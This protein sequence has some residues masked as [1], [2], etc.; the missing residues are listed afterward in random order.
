[1]Y[2]GKTFSSRNDEVHLCEK[3]F[4]L[5]PHLDK[6]IVQSGQTH[7]LIHENGISYWVCFAL[8]GIALNV[9]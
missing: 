1:M 7:L 8:C 4:F 9:S 3:F 2:E 6:T 5:H